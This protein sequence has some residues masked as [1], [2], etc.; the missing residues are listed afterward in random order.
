MVRTERLPLERQ[1]SMPLQVAE[2]AVVG[3][4]V[5][6]IARPFE[7]AAGLVTPVLPTA[8]VVA[9][10]VRPIVC[11]ELTR[12]GQQLIVG[13]RRDR[14]QGRRHD[15]RFAV[16]IELGQ[17]DFVAR[18]GSEVADERVRRGLEVVAAVGEIVDPPA[19]ALRLIDARHERGNDLTQFDEDVPRARAHFLERMREHAEQQRFERLAGSEQSDVRGRR[20]GQQPAKRV[21]RFCADDRLVHA[22]RVLRRLRIAGA[23]MRLHRRNPSRVGGERGVERADEQIPPRRSTQFCRHVV[24]PLPVRAIRIRHVP[25]RLF[26]VRHQA[27]PLEDFGQNVRHAFAGDVGA[28]EL[29]D[30]IVAVLTQ[31]PRVQSVR[32]VAAHRGLRRERTAIELTEKL[33][34]EQSADRLG[35]ARVAGEER[36]FHGFRQV[37]QREDGPIDVGEER[38]ERA[39]LFGRKFD[40]QRSTLNCRG[41]N[42]HRSTL[43]CQGSTVKSQGRR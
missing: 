5:E 37:R 9:Q 17:R 39:R 42:F 27:S 6:A 34:E 4:H 1:Q 13:Q 10:Q 7:C 25:R 36:S 35:R 29:R 26:E 32:A 12:P 15:F 38:C 28:A 14:V 2:R 41:A 43:N 11:G 22:V 33:V 3:Q 31:D 16:R 40:S 30:G 23:E 18:L 21:Q 8:G 24:L 19:A 20:S